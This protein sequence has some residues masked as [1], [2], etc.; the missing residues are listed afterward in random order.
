MRFFNVF[1]K[2]R[3]CFTDK[4]GLESFFLG[5]RFDQSLTSDLWIFFK[6]KILSSVNVRRAL[7]ALKSLKKALKILNKNLK[8][9]NSTFYLI[10]Y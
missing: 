10:F 1:E 8:V 2:K 6:E 4:V 9:E 3:K 7:K 5:E